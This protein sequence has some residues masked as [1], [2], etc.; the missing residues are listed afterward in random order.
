MPK[1]T[2]IYD[3][4]VRKRGKAK[5]GLVRPTIKQ[6]STSYPPFVENHI[7][8]NMSNPSSVD[9]GNN[10]TFIITTTNVKNG[11]VLYYEITGANASDFEDNTL[12][13]STV[14]NNGSAFIVKELSTN[15]IVADDRDFNIIIRKRGEQGPQVYSDTIGIVNT[16][17]LDAPDAPTI[18][19]AQASGL[20][21]LV[22]FSAPAYAGT[23]PITSYTA[24]SSSGN[25]TGSVN[26]SGSGTINVTGLVA[27]TT[28]TFK[29]KA[30]NT[31]G[32]SGWSSSSN[33]ITTQNVPGTP[34]IGT[35]S[36]IISSTSASIAYSAPVSNGG[37]SITSYTAIS[38]PGNITT[39]V[40][41]A[42]SGSISMTGLTTGIIYNFRVK[43][44]NSIGDSSWSSYSN[45][46]TP[47]FAFTQTTAA[48]T[49]VASSD[50]HIC[51]GGFCGWTYSPELQ[52]T[53]PKTPPIITSLSSSNYPSTIPS[54]YVMRRVN[55]NGG[56]GQRTNVLNSYT[57]QTTLD[58]AWTIW[59]AAASI[60]DSRV[61]YEFSTAIGRYV[62]I[63]LC[64]ST[65]AQL[66]A[67][68]H[69]SP[70]K[71]VNGWQYSYYGRFTTDDINNSTPAGF[72]KDSI[73]GLAIDRLNNKCW[74]SLNG[75][76]QSG[77]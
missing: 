23:S 70:G 33:N 42:G 76:W 46:V 58:S 43:A 63:G 62:Y 73:I 6:F 19:T 32:N 54:G 29:V 12:V 52:L 74:Y 7:T 45:N 61:Y 31:V 50:L 37:A 28:Y 72:G 49:N 38:N 48:F 65:N 14:V 22:A 64:T 13:G 53:H 40:S 9:E 57:V 35:A 47:P 44:T 77:Q 27:G 69:C 41:R 36:A 71:E 39:S 3:I 15:S 5:Q 26:Q 4:V 75:V 17:I 68:G 1:L 16:T 56:T 21:A 66:T 60:T 51:V 55:F 11:D 67:A 20:T 18:G 30:T 2:E 59:M 25:I 34:T 24:I 8:Y 10:I